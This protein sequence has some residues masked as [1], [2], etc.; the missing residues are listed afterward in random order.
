[1]K[2]LYASRMSHLIKTIEANAFEGMQFS[3]PKGG[4]FLC[5]YLENGTRYDTIIETLEEMHI[6]LIDIRVCFMEEYRNTKYIRLSVSKMDQET[7]DFAVPKIL[8]VIRKNTLPPTR[9]K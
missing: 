8:E 6:Q 4:Y 1:M 7:I 2:A 9:L 3:R 5:I